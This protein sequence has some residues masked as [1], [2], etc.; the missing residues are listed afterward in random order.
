MNFKNR[1]D[2]YVATDISQGFNFTEEMV[3]QES[4]QQSTEHSVG[5]VRSNNI[6]IKRLQLD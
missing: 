2:M 3:Q 6:Q 4:M 1:D 5:E